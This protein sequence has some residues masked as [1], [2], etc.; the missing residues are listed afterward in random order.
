M[1]RLSLGGGSALGGKT[2]A[3]T[4]AI[5]VLTGAA[6][7]EN[8]GCRPCLPAQEREGRPVTNFSMGFSLPSLFLLH[9]QQKIGAG[10][11]A[12]RAPGSKA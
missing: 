3:S 4:D 10:C 8:Q 1:G 12:I 6:R 2:Y 7:S 11:A 9:E 5:L